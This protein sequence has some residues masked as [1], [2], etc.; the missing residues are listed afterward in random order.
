MIRI[1]RVSG[2]K[3]SGCADDLALLAMIDG[4]SRL[5]KPRGLPVTD[6][7][8]DKALLVEHN[9]VDFAT[10]TAKVACDRA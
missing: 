8:E 3:K 10:A 6:L 2:A 1:R 5:G 7:G 4:K 9:Q